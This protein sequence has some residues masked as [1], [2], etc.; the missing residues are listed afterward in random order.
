MTI[1]RFTETLCSDQSRLWDKHDLTD[2]SACFYVGM[3]F[4]GFSK[5]KTSVDVWTYPALRDTAK[6]VSHPHCN[7][8]RLMPKVAQ[9]QST[10]PAVLAEHPD[11]MKP[12]HLRCRLY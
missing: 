3:S 2:V 9:I 5:R 1:E 11:R 4:T 10:S 6:N 12:G 8:P 7:L